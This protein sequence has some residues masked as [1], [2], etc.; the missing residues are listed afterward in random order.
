MPAAGCTLWPPDHRMV[1]VG[2]VT[3]TDALSGLVP[4]SFNVTG[5]VNEKTHP[6][7]RDIIV[8]PAKSGGFKVL[9]EAEKNWNGTDRVY[10]LTATAMDLAGNKASATASCT[11]PQHKK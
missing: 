7:D 5:T 9:L 10:T 6:G 3:A 4:G 11:V 2:T 8:V 1:Q